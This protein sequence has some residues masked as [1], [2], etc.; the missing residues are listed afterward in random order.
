[1]DKEQFKAQVAEAV[2]LE[3]AKRL[4]AERTNMLIAMEPIVLEKARL[5]ERLRRSEEDHGRLLK[6][7]EV[8]RM[9]LGDS[10]ADMTLQRDELASRV[11]E[12]ENALQLSR[13]EIAGLERERAEEE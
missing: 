11:T 13:D 4:R 6:Q 1:M 8:A 3:I 7:Y 10:L 5:A 12:L 2:E 9:E